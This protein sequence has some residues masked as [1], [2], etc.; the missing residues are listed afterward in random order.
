[1]DFLTKEEA[2]NK[3]EKITTDHKTDEFIVVLLGKYT[4]GIYLQYDMT[5]VKNIFSNENMCDPKNID[6]F[7][8]FLSKFI[9]KSLKE[10]KTLLLIFAGHGS[11]SKDNYKLMFDEHGTR[12][13]IETKKITEAIKDLRDDY[14][15]FKCVGLI[16]AC[17]SNFF[18]ISCFDASIT[19]GN[20]ISRWNLLVQALLDSIKKEKFTLG[21]IYKNLSDHLSI[22][23]A[24][25]PI[26]DE[27][28]NDRDFKNIEINGNYTFIQSF[29]KPGP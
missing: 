18:D 13:D 15:K 4:K 20:G 7:N 14:P 27:N 21:D 24:F 2:Q 25:G 9:Q 6:E 19:L 5:E 8:N 12:F 28:E 26:G 23:S 29:S 22:M 3:I 16:Q 1:M 10:D 17:Y 11:N